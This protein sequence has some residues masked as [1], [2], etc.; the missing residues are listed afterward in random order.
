MISFE[1]KLNA[2]GPA[3]DPP[4]QLEETMHIIEKRLLDTISI[5]IN[6]SSSHLL[7][8]YMFEHDFHR[9]SISSIMDRIGT[10]K[11]SRHAYHRYYEIFLQ[12]FRDIRG[13][14]ILEIGAQS[15][16]SIQL[17]SEYFSDPLLMHGVSY[18]EDTRSVDERKTVCDWNPLSCDKVT[19]FRGDLS[20]P[21]FLKILA[22]R[23]NY[24]I[25]IDG[26][27]DPAHQV[28]SLK[29]LFTSLKPGGLYVLEDLE[30]S[31]WN[32]PDASLHG[33]SI[34]AGIG[35]P[36]TASTVEKLKQ[37]IDVMMRFH[38]AHPGLHIFPDDDKFFSVTF[39]QG[40]AFIRKGTDEEIQHSPVVSEAPVIHSGV[41]EWAIKAMEVNQ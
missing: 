16:K 8:G 28:I 37:F 23:Y 33:Y 19:I 31:Y 20:D 35:C 2:Y 13:L 39:G 30:T 15:G 5:P 24:D 34:K 25:I 18:G 10:D 17:W 14:S 4:A 22:E 32:R 9:E 40:I 36:P 41:D 11:F 21:K 7:N 3:Q 1:G 29:H 26:S 6:T 12:E 27:H 38:M